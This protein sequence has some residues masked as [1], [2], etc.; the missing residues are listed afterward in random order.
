VQA[1]STFMKKM[2]VEGIA[3]DMDGIS[4]EFAVKGPNELPEILPN[5][6]TDVGKLFFNPKEV[7]CKKRS[8]CYTS[9]D[10]LSRPHGETWMRTLTNF[11]AFSRWD[12]ERL[13]SQL[14]SFMEVK[15]N[16]KQM[17][18]RLT[19][20]QIRRYEFN[21]SINFVW[22]RLMKG[23]VD[24]PFVQINKLET[25]FIEVYNPSDQL[26]FIHFVLHNVTQHG[27]KIQVLP[28]ALR[29][30]S[31]CVLST[32]SP[33]S[34]NY[35][36][37]KD[38][39]M[40]EIKPRASL[41]IGINFFA[42]SAGTYSTL[43]YLRNNLTVLEAV[44]LS[45]RAVIP[46]FKFG[47]RKP[48]NATPLQ[49]E[50][51]EKHL[52]LC[53]KKTGAN[54]LISSK[55]TFTAKNYGEVPLHIYG[56]KI[57]NDLCVGYGFKVLNCESFQLQ[58]NESRKI[59]IAFSPDFTLTR[60]VRSLNFDT[61][62]GSNVNFTL[63]GT[64][65]SSALEICSK[66]IQ[67]PTWEADF[68][69]K[70]LIVLW[71]ALVLVL[72]AS[73]IDS[74]RILKEH[75]RLSAREK[76]P[77]Q[78]PLDLRKI[79]LEANSMSN[80][81]AC[82]FGSSQH[83]RLNNLNNH[84]TSLNYINNIRKR[85]T[86]TKNL[87]ALRNKIT[88]TKTMH[89]N[90]TAASK[91]STV[92]V[93]S[94]SSSSTNIGSK[95]CKQ[96]PQNCGKEN[97]NI[98]SS[99]SS[100]RISSD[101]DNVSSSSSSKENCEIS[102][103]SSHKVAENSQDSPPLAKGKIGSNKKSKNQLNI[104]EAIKDITTS[105]TTITT[106]TATIMAKNMNASQ[107]KPVKNVNANIKQ[108]TKETKNKVA[109]NNHTSSS[110]IGKIVN[111]MNGELK[112]HSPTSNASSSEGQQHSLSDMISDGSENSTNM[113]KVSDNTI[114]SRLRDDHVL[115]MML[116]YQ[117]ETN[118]H[119]SKAQSKYGKTPGRE[120]K[121]PLNINN[122]SS[123]NNNNN[124]N[125]IIKRITPKESKHFGFKQNLNS[126]FANVG[127]G[128]Q[129]GSVYQNISNW[130][131]PSQN[132]WS[133]TS[134]SEVV[135]QP[136]APIEA[137]SNHTFNLL[138]GVTTAS[139]GPRQSFQEHDFSRMHSFNRSTDQCFVDHEDG[140]QFG[141]IGTRKSPS[142]TPS[143]EPLNAGINHHITKPS[144]S[145]SYFANQPNFGIQQ[146]KLLNLMSYNDANKQQIMDERYQYMMKMKERQQNEWNAA[147]GSLW[148]ATNWAT[149][150]PPLNVPPGFE[151]QFQQQP[152]QQQPL[153]PMHSLQ[154]QQQQQHQQQQQQ[155]QQLHQQQQQQQL[156]QQ[157]AQ[158][159]NGQIAT[160]DS[161]DPFKSLSAIWEPNSRN[162]TNGDHRDVWNQ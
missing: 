151:Q 155:Q 50:I 162:D 143:W 69:S 160:Y 120:R 130:I 150:S 119:H 75:T 118:N 114:E 17:Q 138:N 40:D 6:D 109:L 73:G 70:V 61:S 20:S 137:K 41:K 37:N 98:S 32:E 153:Q 63:I 71:I 140:S 65:A 42:T 129:N 5:I 12:N 18:F 39:F 85:L 145:S 66:N 23:N 126:A 1:Y 96:D 11:T 113:I 16:I 7:L 35:T 77:V 87:P 154:Q 111:G 54:V 38:I 94:P 142:S 107:Q 106:A 141:P 33:F 4:Y 29:D 2:Y 26:M 19:T 95:Q 157:H 149:P 43:L 25:R 78:E 79:G 131:A 13:R 152:Q 22:P 27:D 47:N 132:I 101:D 64:V 55:R 127:K 123:N 88:G 91:N 86:I 68:K 89:N 46:Q 62:I 53:E 136:L 115:I 90:E 82:T 3:V 84:H 9:F 103:K 102:G 58:P 105:S 36:R 161:Y 21:A 124:H 24:F 34:F 92:K 125:N 112:S 104:T 108:T 14:N 45:A 144:F 52:K 60:V 81:I 147:P 135:A 15:Q 122:S 146:S 116:I 76:G 100:K 139:N 28:E 74:D 80:G 99:S 121:A 134:Y 31:H 8:T 158:M 156:Q 128:M 159:Q 56:M 44:W 117:G 83:E 72:F 49:F 51:N 67:R 10:V 93:S 30:C 110:S 57:E 97:N 48:G 148:S 59:E 133:N